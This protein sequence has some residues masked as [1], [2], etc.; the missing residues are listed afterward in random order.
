MNSVDRRLCMLS[1]LQ[2]KPCHSDNRK[3]M[4]TTTLAATTVAATRKRNGTQA[5]KR[6]LFSIVRSLP[7]PIAKVF[8]ALR[9]VFCHG[10]SIKLFYL[11]GQKKRIK[12]EKKQ[13]NNNSKRQLH[14][15]KQSRNEPNK[16][17]YDSCTRCCKTIWPGMW[18]WWA[19]ARTRACI[20]LF[21]LWA[22]SD[23]NWFPPK[24]KL[25]VCVR[26]RSPYIHKSKK[27]PISLLFDRRVRRFNSI[28]LHCGEEKV[29]VLSKPTQIR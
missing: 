1:D 5:S 23:W 26:T 19:S 25:F 18:I 28:K 9:W 6:L 13:N 16:K 14:T 21:Y 29:C 12:T 7:K 17:K 4:W 24:F 20:R 3:D 15:S 8:A 22:K 10:V 11:G 27:M 2:T